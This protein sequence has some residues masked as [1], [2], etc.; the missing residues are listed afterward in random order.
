[1]KTCRRFQIVSRPIVSHWSI[2]C[3]TQQ[4][5]ITLRRWVAPNDLNTIP[6]AWIFGKIYYFFRQEI[7]PTSICS[8]HKN[9]CFLHA[10]FNFSSVRKRGEKWIFR[11]WSSPLL[12]QVSHTFF[13]VFCNWLTTFLWTLI[14]Y[15]MRDDIKKKI[16][17]SV[18]E[19]SFLQCIFPCFYS[20]PVRFGLAWVAV[21][22]CEEE[23]GRRWEGVGVGEESGRSSRFSSSSYP[24]AASVSFLSRDISM[25]TTSPPIH[26]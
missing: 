7:P 15:F 13:F 18:R 11:F 3:A 5:L 8:C 23:L 1:M 21:A 6:P 4:V 16:I 19:N 12:W 17:N 20:N 2:H 10:C 24:P 14:C 22:F 26:W 25:F 9:F